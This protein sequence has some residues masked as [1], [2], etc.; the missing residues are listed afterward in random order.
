MI[1]PYAKY[2]CLNIRAE[3]YTPNIQEWR[4]EGV[5]SVINDSKEMMK[6]GTIKPMG[7]RDFNV[8]NP[9]NN[10]GEKTTG[11]SQQYFT[12]SGEV[13]NAVGLQYVAY[14]KTAAYKRN[15]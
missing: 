6:C 9:S 5:L 14:P 8:E 7:T 1:P 4:M 3:N 10:G 2:T 13:T 11:A 12:I 15:I